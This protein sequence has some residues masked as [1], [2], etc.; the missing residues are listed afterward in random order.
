MCAARG[1]G[2]FCR[3]GAVV[4]VFGVGLL[5]VMWLSRQFDLAKVERAELN[6]GAL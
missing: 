3:L 1:C 6:G 5:Q 4:L 2:K